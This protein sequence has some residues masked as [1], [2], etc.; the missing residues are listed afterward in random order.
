DDTGV[1]AKFRWLNRGKERVAIHLKDPAGQTAARRLAARADVLVE[2]FRPGV[3]ARLGLGYDALAEMNP[4]LIYCSITGFGQTGP[5]RDV[6]GH[7]INYLAW[8]GALSLAGGEE[9]PPQ[10]PGVQVADL[11][12][13]AWVAVTAILAALRQRDRTG[14]GQHLDVAMVD[15]VMSWLSVHAADAWALGRSPR[16]GERMLGGDFACYRVYETLDG[17]Y[18]SVGAVEN[19]FWRTLCQ[20]VGL[21]Q[22]ADV[23]YAPDPL[24]TEAIRAFEAVFRSRT[25]DDWCEALAGLDVCVAPVLDVHEALT[26]PHARARKAGDPDGRRFPVRWSGAEEEGSGGSVVAPADP[27]PSDGE[28]QGRPGAAWRI[29]S[30]TLRVLREAGFSEAEIQQLRERGAIRT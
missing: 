12:G 3:M 30:H 27:L 22:Y 5:L 9:G 1:S 6:A 19:R 11:G 14:R 13:G 8:A 25:R 23:Q 2:G 10:V 28:G 21:P 4:G 16:P 20:A 18:L 29:G 24:R 26:S 15:G 17:R 7:D